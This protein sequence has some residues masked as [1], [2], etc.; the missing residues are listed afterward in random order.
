MSRPRQDCPMLHLLY[1]ML[2][3]AQT[4]SRTLG[5][6]MRRRREHSHVPLFAS[7]LPDRQ[8]DDQRVL[9][10]LSVAQSSSGSRQR[11]L[12][13]FLLGLLKAPSLD[14]HVIITKE[15]DGDCC[16]QPASWY[17]LLG[18][19]DCIAC[20]IIISMYGAPEQ[21]TPMLVNVSSRTQGPRWK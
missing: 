13:C 19:L 17:G 9:S 4:R 1:R 12:G 18:W 2:E 14:L 8:V 21:R 15:T 5:S 7:C 11:R 16:R 6:F 10:C 20:H 3:V